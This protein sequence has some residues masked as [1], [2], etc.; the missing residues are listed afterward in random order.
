MNALKKA[1]KYG[2]VEFNPHSL[3]LS[4]PGNNKCG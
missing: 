4:F 2:L 3:P 1:A